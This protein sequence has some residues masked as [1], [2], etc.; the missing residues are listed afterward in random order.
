MLKI[1]K[2]TKVDTRPTVP[3]SIVNIPIP[4]SSH[5]H[6]N[7][8]QR[9]TKFSLVHPTSTG[10]HLDDTTKDEDAFAKR[11]LAT[12]GSIYFRQRK[13]YPRCFLWRVVGGN[14][15]GDEDRFLE[16]QPVDLTKSVSESTGATGT[17]TAPTTAAT[18]TTKTTTTTTNS[19]TSNQY[20]QH[21]ANLL[22]RLEFPEKIIPHGVALA[23]LVDHEVLSLFVVTRDRQL[24]TIS[25]RQEFFRRV[26]AID[27][28]VADWCKVSCPAPLA[29]AH[30]HRLHVSSP[31]ELFI[32]LDSGALL[33]LTRK[34]G[35]DGSH[36]SAITFDEKPWGSSLRGL[37]KWSGHQQIRYD[38][39][40]LDPNT[41]N[42]I[43]T[44]SDQAF[45]FVVGLNHTLKIWNL[46]SHKLVAS[47][48]MLDRTG[49][50]QDAA[51]ATLNPSESA[52]IRVFNAERAMEGETHYA[53]TYSPLDDGQFK[54]WAVK[55][56]L[57]SQLEV[58]D[59]FPDS[60]LKPADP[61][62]SGSVF[63]NIADFQIK[64]MEEGRHMVL[65]VLW[66]NN[67]LYQ[68]FSLHFNLDDLESAWLH[69]WTG[70]A[71]ET[72]GDEP[73]PSF[74]SSDIV[75]PTEKWLEYLFY[76][77]KYS[78][79]VLATSLAIYQDAMKI[80]QATG[81]KKSTPLQQQLCST[82]S[83]SVSLRKFSE[84]GVDY[85]KY[86]RE[87]DAKWRQF[88]QIADNLNKK[89]SQAISLSYDAFTDLPWL[90]F[91]DGCCIIR[92]CSST[93]LLVHNDGHVLRNHRRTLEDSMHHR[94]LDQELTDR[95]DLA[96][97]LIEAASSFRKKFTPELSR[98]CTTAL[99][100]ELFTEP[101]LSVPQRIAAFHAQSKFSELIT[102][103]M[104][105]SMFAAVDA[106]IGFKTLTTELFLS[107]IDTMPLGFPGK[108]SEL[109]STDFGRMVT[110]QGVL[111]TIWLNRQVLYDLLVL[112][113][114]VETELTQED[115]VL[116]DGIDLFATLIELL[117]EYEMM[118]WLGSNVRPW[119]GNPSHGSANRA[120]SPVIHK[121]TETDKRDRRLSTILEDLF[122]CHIK[123]RPTFAVP[124]TFTITQQLRDVVSWITRQGE[125]S[126]PNVLV[127]IQ[128]DLLASENIDLASDFLRF[129]PNTAWS[130]YVKGRLY[131]A[132][133]EFDAA[134]IYFQKAAYILS[135][136]KAVG[137][138]HEM[139]SNLLDIISVN[140]FYNGLPKYFQHIL[141]LFEQAR[142]FAHV[143]DFARLALQALESDPKKNEPDSDYIYL[144]TDLLSRLFHASLK[145]CRFDEAYSALSRYTDVALQKSALTS[146]VTTI[147]AAS[148]PGTAGLQKILRFP[149]SLS[150][151][152]ST[153]VDEVLLSL[154]KKQSTHGRS[155]GQALPTA[156]SWQGKDDIPD[157]QRVL[158]AYRV[159]RNDI[160]GAAEV[161]YQTVQRLREMRDHGFYSA[162]GLM[163]RQNAK[164]TAPPLRQEVDED[165]LESKNLRNELL[166][167][168]N[169]LACMD[170]NEAYILVEVPTP[171]KNTGPRGSS[172]ISTA[173]TADD[174]S[175][176]LDSTTGR[177]SPRTSFSFP[178]PANGTT[179]SPRS[180][181]GAGE[182]KFSTTSSQH[183]TGPQFQPQQSKLPKRIIVTLEDLRREYQAELDRVSRI[184][185]G[186]WEFGYVE[187]GEGEMGMDM[188]ND[189]N[190]DNMGGWILRDLYYFSL[191]LF[192]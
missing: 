113:V 111:E 39:R 160:R 8:Q 189:E 182:R 56:G 71:L 53:V 148:G 27:E 45:V 145:T 180:N 59:L 37:V 178:S 132:K 152:L 43:A 115:G 25:L 143:A 31:Q 108:D 150:P 131:V 140:S 184:E 187:G 29:F 185:N 141:S 62:P 76:P 98:A 58:E 162:R 85:T 95:S 137:N 144:R 168:I 7:P 36:W 73:P 74:L 91:S 106:T 69:N 87:T 158:Q 64:A 81:F 86:R 14:D 92:E 23:D 127:F 120:M 52:F 9:R 24:Y 101:S 124:Q 63:W 172:V 67:N 38:G 161:S 97:R 163:M 107:I 151:N 21:E 6:S 47:K 66:R 136:G 32:S 18:A 33:R 175:V 142:A 41:S 129:Q 4:S 139:S 79:E 191:D 78:R 134:A 57:T 105:D 138:L 126:F 99:N 28:N 179:Y 90:L 123:P 192:R 117:K 170:K 10:A 181:N 54:F 51:P 159:A 60:K 93:E 77:G 164:E 157:Y 165:D 50:Q 22:L 114:F 173:A 68:I 171:S 190:L 1:Y 80:K 30:P 5:G 16:I 70:M 135:Q 104:F 35:D 3:A 121:E 17:S 110:V 119:P 130:T 44:T 154:A 20:Q 42:A 188:M 109:V 83:E 48:D 94:N 174:S 177:K 46:A 19:S 102:D 103:D 89:R 166:S 167:L 12:Q 26:A 112:T 55:G 118:L 84:A 15:E 72:R 176:F 61:D 155:Q 40:V 146:L 147:L 82:I 116:F 133:S 125:V 153:H 100:A 149:I 128:C 96:A 11:Y 49:Q 75:D 186:D 65:W 122:A 88:W 156:A 169:L 13:T 34:A 183:S 2:E